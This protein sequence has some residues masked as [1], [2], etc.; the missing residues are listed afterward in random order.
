[1]IFK[2]LKYWLHCALVFLLFILTSANLTAQEKISLVKGVVQNDNNEPLGG[3]SVIL[4]NIKTNFTLGTS[5][6][7]SGIFNFLRVPA[8]GPYSFTFSTVGFETQSLSGYNIK[9]DITLSLRVKMKSTVASLDQVIV[10][11]YGTQQK[12]D[13]TGA[14]G[15]ITAA[16]TK[17]LP[18]PSIDQRMV[19]QV[20][21]MQVSAATG[22]PGGGTS[23]RIRGAGSIGAGNDP[24]FVIDGFPIT[25]SFGQT[26]N[27]LNLINPD[28]IESITVLKDASST[29]IYGSRGS[30]GVVVVTTKR[31]RSGPPRVEVT[32]YTGWQTVPKKGRPT[33]LNGTEY[34]QYQK[35]WIEDYIVATQRRVATEMDI[36]AYLRSP[37]QYGEGTNW[38]NEILQTAPQSSINASV[39]GGS[40]NSKYSFSLGRVN[41]DGVVKYTGFE[42]Y[43]A[44]MNF[45]T[46]ISRKL[47]LG[48]VIAPSNSVQKLSDSEGSLYRDNIIVRSL[49]LSPLVPVTD[50][51]GKRTPFIEGGGRPAPNPLNSL[52]FAGT[53]RK[54][55][56]GLGSIFAEYEIL[57][58]LKA[59]YSFNVD[60]SNGSSFLFNPSN[61]GG[62]F[63]PPPVVPNS[64]TT[65]FS[66][67]N[68][69][70]EVLLSYNKQINDDH[71]FETVLGYTTQREN[72][73]FLQINA[74]N[75]PDNLVQ[76]FN[77][78]A[79]IPSYNQD[80]Q[81]WSL[82]S[83]LARV[84]YTF[85]NKY[86]LTATG[87][88]DGSSRFGSNNRYGHFPSAA[89]AW[90]A[91]DE[92]FFNNIKW[93]SN[94]KF[95][96]SYGL[97]GNYNIGNYTWISNI[98]SSNAVF[99]GQI[100]GGRVATS[101]NNPDLTWEESVQYDAGFDF[102]LF[103]DRLV[104]T[105]DYY[106][107]ITKSMLL[108]N[109]IP[110]SSGYSNAIFNLGK[111]RNQGFEFSLSS[112]NFTGKFS[113]NTRANI[114]FNRNIVLAL[115]DQNK[116]IYSGRSGE[117]GYTHITEV[118]KPIGQFFGY[119]ILGVYKDAQ[120]LAK[121]AKNNTSVV[122]SIKYRDVDGNGIIEQIKDF[123]VIGKSQPD[124][125]WGLSNNF[126]YSNF[127]LTV[128]LVGV[129]GGQILRTANE[130]HNNN[131]GVAFPAQ[132]NIDRKYVMNR[133]RS[134][135]Q[136]GDG[137]TPSTTGGRVMWRDVNSSW[138]EDASYLRVQNVTLSYIISS[139]ILS[140]TNV[141]KTA[142]VYISGQNLS[143]LTKYS[144]GNPDAIRN[145]LA[146][147]TVSQALVPGSDYGN[148][149]V[150]RSINIGVN[151]GF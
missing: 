146:G 119:Q 17:D 56:R 133:W 63:L 48:V 110:L 121:S 102:G 19:G 124:F 77:A 122:G 1:M 15:I 57:R 114:S 106:N 66:S 95:R 142:R 82:I 107:K 54:E 70:S 147:N 23:I 73:N 141:I 115:N 94:L 35:E 136:P 6:D 12:R 75:Y 101:L 138:V 68:W 93:M 24:L 10:I 79:I 81:E 113:W 13:L 83:Y 34:A 41:Q 148:Y 64:T 97:A 2:Q 33:V 46:N 143:I 100:A 5:T 21:G 129:Q 96:S 84:N 11:G 32:A 58:G 80:I 123:T 36:P 118:G 128:I 37:S 62:I 132:F 140:R 90:R 131:E 87:R 51:S 116:S 42:R 71:R 98:G 105:A 135:T 53:T 43:A 16:Q 45:E 134:E 99:G 25:R 31:G 127:D 120:D 104:F 92:K 112:Q 67:F 40:E 125:T 9:D 137:M 3:V 145:S 14:V 50:A 109:E 86:I 38:Y 26:S 74:D 85:K 126:S 22:I 60:Y 130:T 20:A 103:K 59:K 47:K 39:S 28:D 76:T 4:R 144:W 108:N 149:P 27:P 88:T 61:V 65:Q 117:G 69:L 139:K 7:S 49:W 44:R 91:S 52:E 111:V 29:A 8:G 72:A 18:V 78:A 151:L 30:N 150:A 89:V 55:F